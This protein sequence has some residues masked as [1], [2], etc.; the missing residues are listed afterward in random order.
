GFIETDLWRFIKEIKCP[1]IYILGGG[2]RIVPPETQAKLRAELANVDIISMPGLGH[3]P[4]QE[5]T[6]DF[7]GN[8]QAFLT[9]TA[10]PIPK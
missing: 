8:V 9:A 5:A 10:K 1:T 4:D 7:L 6:A 3:Y 2:S